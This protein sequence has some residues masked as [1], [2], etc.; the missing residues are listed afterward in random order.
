[1]EFSPTCPN[2]QISGADKGG[3]NNH[4]WGEPEIWFH[5]IC[6][7]VEHRTR[8]T[9]FRPGWSSPFST[10]SKWEDT[11]HCFLLE[12]SGVI[13]YTA[14][15]SLTQRGTALRKNL[16]YSV[17][18]TQMRWDLHG[19]IEKEPSFIYPHGEYFCAWLP[20]LW[21]VDATL[22]TS[23]LTASSN[24]ISW[25]TSW[26]WN[27]CH[28]KVTVVLMLTVA[29]FHSNFLK[30]WVWCW[31]KTCVGILGPKEGPQQ[32]ELICWF[33]SVPLHTDAIANVQ[34][35]KIWYRWNSSDSGVNSETELS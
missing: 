32:S 28:P 4:W 19:Y 18:E 8:K 14:I 10:L 25:R 31:M 21:V 34:C 9:K 30:H 27:S 5:N 20:K 15:M 17:T 26:Y 11:E 29:S 16:N 22:E 33:P 23:H 1:M 6:L 35:C 12:T 3:E 2:C 13:C 24:W 7:A